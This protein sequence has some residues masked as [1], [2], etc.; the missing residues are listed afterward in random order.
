MT[1]G[2]KSTAELYDA[3]AGAFS[4]TGSMLS[5]R[6]W[7]TLTLLPDGRVLAAGGETEAC[8]GP[9]QFC[10]FGG[11]MASAELYDPVSGAFSATGSMTTAREISYRYHPQRR[12]SSG[13]GGRV[14]CEIRLSP[15]NRKCGVVHAT[16]V[17]TCAAAFPAIGRHPG[18][19]LALTNRTDCCVRQTGPSPERSSRCTPPAWLMAESFLRKSRSELSL[20]K[21]CISATL[22]VIPD[23]FK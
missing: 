6:A 23:I 16:G 13:S 17:D 5:S 2:R 8:S 14:V 22:L 21:S 20:L 3:A 11:T 15:G 9:N 12:Q 7:H 1:S 18:R 10:Y 4:S 19:N